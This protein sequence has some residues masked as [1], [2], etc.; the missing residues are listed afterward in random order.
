VDSQPETDT[1]SQTRHH[2]MPP[3]PSEGIK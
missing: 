3:V 1:R 2:L